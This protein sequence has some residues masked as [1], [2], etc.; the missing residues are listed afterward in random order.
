MHLHSFTTF[1][2]NNVFATPTKYMVSYVI[3]ARKSKSIIGL[4][5]LVAR[6]KINITFKSNLSVCS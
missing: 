2:N 4:K 6:E 3:K 1:T 5:T